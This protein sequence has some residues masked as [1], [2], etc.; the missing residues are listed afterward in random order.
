MGIISWKPLVHVN[1]PNSIIF[2]LYLPNNLALSS[3]D[4]EV[5]LKWRLK[6]NVM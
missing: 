5:A 4:G 1:D 2:V 3:A 6:Y